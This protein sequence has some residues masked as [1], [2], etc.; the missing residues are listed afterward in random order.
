MNHPY[1]MPFIVHNFYYI[2]D[3]KLTRLCK[4]T[5]ITTKVKK[6]PNRFRRTNYI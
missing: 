2:C 6:E 4:L 3:V 1:N 5:Y